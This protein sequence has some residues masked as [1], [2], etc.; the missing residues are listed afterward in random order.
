M[1]IIYILTL[2]T[3]PL[4]FLSKTIENYIVNGYIKDLQN[5]PIEGVDVFI[6]AAYS[7][8]PNP[9]F[10]L[11][12]LQYAEL[13]KKLNNRINIEPNFFNKNGFVKLNETKTNSLGYYFIEVKS[14]ELKKTWPQKTNYPLYEY[15]MIIYMKA[16]YKTEIKL[17]SPFYNKSSNN[18]IMLQL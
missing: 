11:D 13:E 12:S 5:N 18:L 1:K 16:G 4:L 14:K 8:Y 2:F 7:R 15:I 9:S 6:I 10:C 3:L 17:I